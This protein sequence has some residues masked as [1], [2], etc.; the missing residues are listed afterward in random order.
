MI[1]PLFFLSFLALFRL[2]IQ[3]PEDFMT[4]LE[5]ILRMAHFLAGITWIGLLYFF[6]FVNFPVMERLE[7]PVR[8]KLFAALMPKAF[9]WF[10]WGAVVTVFAGMTYF[11]LDLRE[12]AEK[13][14]N[15][16]MW[17]EWFSAWVLIW[18]VAWF[19][20]R[21]LLKYVAN[22]WVRGAGIVVVVFLAG[23]TTLE[24]FWHAQMSDESLAIGIG[25]GI[26]YMLLLNVWLI[27]WPVQKRLIAWTRALME[28][29]TPMP[30]EA[31]ALR[32]LVFRTARASAWL[33][34]PMLF[35]MGAADHFAVMWKR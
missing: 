19:L 1:L 7:P 22:G 16:T 26:G 27:V 28:K 31:A 9:W 2:N 33:T 23:W 14:G 25:G 4:N 18:L 6:N 11:L 10:R 29:G 21:V 5:M 13:A 8:S 34:I 32:L 35:F 15:P 24:T 3:F 17:L 20:A 12:S 30:Q